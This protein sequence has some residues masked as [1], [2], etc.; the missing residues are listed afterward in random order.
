LEPSAGRA[1]PEVLDAS[2][3][4]DDPQGVPQALEWITRP[5]RDD[6]ARAA[7]TA[8]AALGLCGLAIGLLPGEPLPGALLGL[9]ALGA[10][11]PGMAPVQCR[12]DGG[13]VARRVLFA[14]ER[15]PWAAIRRARLGPAGLFVSPSASP[16]RLDRF[17]GL[18][19]PLPRTGLEGERLRERLRQEVARHGL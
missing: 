1:S 2:P 14:W 16:G 13:G 4:G 11:A 3:R 8:L 12:V 6:R 19:L 18:F 9:A 17:R 5:W 10:L 15:R 7:V